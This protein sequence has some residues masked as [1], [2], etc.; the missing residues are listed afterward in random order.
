MARG[1]KFLELTRYLERSG[2]DKIKMSFGEI[3]RIIGFKLCKSA[4][5]YPEYW[6]NTESHSIFFAWM[7]A[8]YVSKQLDL[9]TQSIVFHKL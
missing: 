4:Y 8:G 1:D 2:K 9:I 3:E 7:N 6:S 5:S